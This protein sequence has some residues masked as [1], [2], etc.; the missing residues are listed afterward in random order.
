MSN[1]MNVVD[2]YNEGRLNCTD[3]RVMRQAAAWLNIIG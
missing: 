2:V 3:E 1:T